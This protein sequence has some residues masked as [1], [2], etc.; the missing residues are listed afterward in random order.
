MQAPGK[1]WQVYLFGKGCNYNKL[2]FL[3]AVNDC[4]RQFGEH[5]TQCWMIVCR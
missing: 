3:L 4:T 1:E 5:L 2:S